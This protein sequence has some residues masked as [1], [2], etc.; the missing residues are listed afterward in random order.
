MSTTA[1]T[2]AGA[3]A[4]LV[5]PFIAQFDVD[6]RLNVTSSTTEVV[7]INGIDHTYIAPAADLASAFDCSGWGVNKLLGRDQELIGNLKVS[8]PSS[9]A[10]LKAILSA[11]LTNDVSGGVEAYL[12]AQYDAAFQA[13]FPTFV[14]G[15]SGEDVLGNGGAVNSAV[16]GAQAAADGVV[17]ANESTLAASTVI[18][19][20][21]LSA[22][23][24]EI[25]I[26]GGEGADV[27]AEGLTEPLLNTIFMQ[28][29]Y[30]RILAAVDASGNRTN[31]KLPLA[32][33]DFITFVFDI[34]VTASTDPNTS[35]A[36]D[37]SPNGAAVTD[38]P[39]ANSEVTT[40]SVQMDLGTR[41]IAV[42]IPQSA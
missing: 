29:P 18:Q 42:K 4:G 15:I 11:A 16:D 41:R 14:K 7:T 24:F 8:L 13:A 28:L 23:T 31:N 33:G 38:A 9:G 37:N 35:S 12:E 19:T 36:V 1:S 3:T 22:Y 40:Q 5:C 27:M 26:S 25:D 2:T 21:T 6:S 17:D 10:A 34:N 39:P 32:A 30:A 20:S